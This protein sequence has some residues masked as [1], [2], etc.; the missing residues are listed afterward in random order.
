VGVYG[1]SFSVGHGY[2]AVILGPNGSGKTT[3]VNMMCAILRP[4]KGRG[5]VAGFDVVDEVWEVRKE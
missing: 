1:V 2:V 5:C 4:I 3:A